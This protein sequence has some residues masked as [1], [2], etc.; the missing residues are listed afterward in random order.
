MLALYLVIDAL[1]LKQGA[2]LWGETSVSTTAER[3]CW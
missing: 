2:Y 3:V 1:L